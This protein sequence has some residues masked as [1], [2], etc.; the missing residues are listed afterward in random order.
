MKIKK[1]TAVYLSE[2]GYNNFYYPS[3]DDIVFLKP[4]SQYKKMHWIGSKLTAIQVD[5]CNSIDRNEDDKFIVWID[6]NKLK[7]I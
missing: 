2:V 4:G 5:G 1:G 7:T 6:P 3:L